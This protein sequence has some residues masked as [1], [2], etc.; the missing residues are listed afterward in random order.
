MPEKLLPDGSKNPNDHPA[1]RA[2]AISGVECMVSLARVFKA[3]ET[4]HY[5]YIA[6]VIVDLS[7][8]LADNAFWKQHGA[9]LVPVYK[10]ALRATVSSMTLRMNKNATPEMTEIA[11]IQKTIWHG[12][13]VTAYDCLYGVIKS[14]DI[15]PAM[16]QEL[17]RIL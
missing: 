3:L 2:E 4:H 1:M 7:F 12:I 9:T 5:S 8:G 14:I 15:A 16:L 10:N 13:F 17:K 11:D 6:P